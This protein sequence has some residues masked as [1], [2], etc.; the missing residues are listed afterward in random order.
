MVLVPEDA[1]QRY[2]QRQRLGTSP[3]MASIMREDTDMSNILQRTDLSDDEK[4]KL[5]YANLERYLDLWRQKDRPTLASPVVSKKE[6]P[7]VAFGHLPA[8]N[9]ER[10]T[11]LLNLLKVKPDL[12]SWDDT[13]Q[14]KL[15]GETIPQTNISDLVTDAVNQR[16]RKTFIPTGS[17]E[18]FNVLTKMNV[19]KEIVR[20]EVR[21]NQMGE[22]SSEEATSSRTPMRATSSRTQMRP[23]PSKYI[24]SIVDKYEQTPKRWHR[25]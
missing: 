6:S 4:Q 15:E 7:N 18:F 1:L 21:W 8:A 10:A 14:V 23:T 24:Q 19:P 17:K 11:A 12:V 13:G 2:E 9:R 3:I 16:P 5:Y 20:N 22:P 25:L